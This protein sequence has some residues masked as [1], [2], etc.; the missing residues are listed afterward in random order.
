MIVIAWAW[1]NS[2]SRRIRCCIR[3]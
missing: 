1:F 2:H 3:R